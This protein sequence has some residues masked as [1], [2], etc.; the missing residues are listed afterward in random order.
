[1]NVGDKTSP[2]VGCFGTGCI[3]LLVVAVI[4]SM[5][6]ECSSRERR[7]DSAPSASQSAAAPDPAMRRN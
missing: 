1:M 7:D 5:S 3:V 4:G 6:G 2:Q